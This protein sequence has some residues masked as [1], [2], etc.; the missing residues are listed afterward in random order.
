[1]QGFAKKGVLKTEAYNAV[2]H[3]ASIAYLQG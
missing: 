2:A 3:T 1:M